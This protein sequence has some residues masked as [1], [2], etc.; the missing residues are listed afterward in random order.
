MTQDTRGQRQRGRTEPL[1][2]ISLQ[3]RASVAEAI[4][5]AVKVGEAPNASAFIED[6]VREHLRERRRDR[7]YGA[8][9][10]ASRDPVFMAEMAQLLD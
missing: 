2:T 9:A 10:V 4:R 6:L 8:Y 3:L 1:E 7:V 5:V